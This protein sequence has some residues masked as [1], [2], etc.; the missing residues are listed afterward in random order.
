MDGK[1]ETRMNTGF[2]KLKWNM[3]GE[4]GQDCFWNQKLSSGYLLPFADWILYP[5]IS[6]MRADCFCRCRPCGVSD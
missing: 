6:R 4:D 1:K 2:E 5:Q 3:D